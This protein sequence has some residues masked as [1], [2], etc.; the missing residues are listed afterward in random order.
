VRRLKENILY[1]LKVFVLT[2]TIKETITA[3]LGLFFKELVL[4]DRILSSTIFLVGWV[5]SLYLVFHHGI[6]GLDRLRGEQWDKDK[7]R[8][9]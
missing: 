2:L 5:I 3:T 6:S 4:R 9:N 7:G 1:L 8:N